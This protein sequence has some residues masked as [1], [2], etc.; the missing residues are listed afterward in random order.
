V[1]ILFGKAQSMNSGLKKITVGLAALAAM[2]VSANAAL[3]KDDA[4][5][6][7]RLLTT[8]VANEIRDNCDTI[9]ARKIK[10]TLYVLGIVSYAKKQGFS[11]AEIEAYKDNP[12]EQARLRREGYAYLDGHGVDREA[13][14][15]YCELGV[16]EMAAKSPIGK[17]LKP[18]N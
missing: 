1:Y 16:A 15:G 2:A 11:M 18:A 13:G 3:I 5:V 8:A 14:T 17:I 7:A 12:D 9:E 6:F 4:E 10:A